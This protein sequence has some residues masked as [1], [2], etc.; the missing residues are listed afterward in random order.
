[1]AKET[2]VSK[3]TLKGREI[4]SSYAALTLEGVM[5]A[6]V[7]CGKDSWTI[8]ERN[9]IAK[10]TSD[11]K[12][13]AIYIPNDKAIASIAKNIVPLLPKKVVIRKPEDIL[14][15][16]REFD[17]KLV[18]NAG[19]NKKVWGGNACLAS[20]TVFFQTLLKASGFKPWEM[21]TNGKKPATFFMP[22]IAFNMVCGG[23]HVP[24]TK[25]DIQE[26][27]FFAM[28]EKSVKDVFVTGTK[29]FRQF[30]KNLVRDGLPTGT[31]KERGF[32]FPVKDNFEGLRRIKECAK[33]LGLTE[34]DYAIGTDNAFSEIQK[35]EELRAAGKYDMRFSGLGV[36]TREQLIDFDYS[37]VASAPNFV[38]MEDPGSESDVVAHKLMNEKYGDRVQ[39][40]IDD[41]AVTQLRYIIPFLA[42][43]QR[44]DRAGNSV[45]I[46]L[47]QAGTFTE[48]CLATQ[49]VLGCADKATV[50]AFLTARGDLSQVL[51]D[52]KAVG[53]G[54]LDAALD[55]IASNGF[56]AFFSHRSTEGS[57][58]F[59]PLMPLLF[60]AVSRRV[61]FKA[62][63][64]NGE[65]NLQDPIRSSA[66][67]KRCARGRDQDRRGRIAGAAQGCEDPCG[68][69]RAVYRSITG[70]MNGGARAHPS[71]FS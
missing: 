69:I 40:V 35:T 24:G 64:P 47:N 42:A 65:R 41:A 28:N 6:R 43:K 15:A 27:F 11:G 26:M 52:L 13:E 46:K 30:E 68:K 9:G 58:E 21:L 71:L 4:L 48:T 60:G 18:K 39:I 36:K 5:T 62:G 57:S 38:T 7:E 22:N 37:V 23:E 17:L 67:R 44:K 56:S 31:A 20:S 19:P 2:I 55:N 1:M 34:K 59:L 70:S 45:L 33:Q 53:V 32:V 61:W 50:K 3:F 51:A 16:V 29:F 8:E 54:S 14:D 63:A 49:V 12:N 66:P 25:Q 10:G